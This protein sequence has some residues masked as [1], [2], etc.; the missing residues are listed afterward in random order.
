MLSS[1]EILDV[2]QQIGAYQIVRRIGDDMFSAIYLAQYLSKPEQLVVLKL[3]NPL[4]H[5]TSQLHEAFL[6][7]AHLLMQCSHP[8]ILPVIEFSEEHGYVYFVTPYAVGGSLRQHLNALAPAHLSLT[9]AL[10]LLQQ[11]GEAVVYLHQRDIIHCDLKPENILLNEQGQVWLADLG[12]A[13]PETSSE[14]TVGKKQAIGS[15]HYMAPEQFA[16]RVSVASDQYALGCIAYELLTGHQPFTGLSIREIALRHLQE[17]PRPP[18]SLVPSLPASIDEAVL[19]ALAKRPEERYPDVTTFLAALQNFAPINVTSRTKE[20]WL[21]EGER[22]YAEKCYD[23]ALNAYD[24]ALR[25][26][27]R[28]AYTCIAKALTLSALERY[29]EALRLLAYAIEQEPAEGYIHVCRGYIFLQTGRYAEAL[30]AY[31]IALLLDPL[32]DE[33]L[34]G[35]EL[36]IQHP[37]GKTRSN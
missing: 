16:G 35:R 30:S 2:G 3:A 31:N 20:E 32:D 28:D 14:A 27:E 1:I 4:E 26:D 7:E 10:A 29:D 19:R 15:L 5:S 21:A 18:S 24:A 37:I 34:A 9:D 11:I 17:A 22:L 36:A 23:E 33:A 12:L 25:C 8:H 6:Q 13:R